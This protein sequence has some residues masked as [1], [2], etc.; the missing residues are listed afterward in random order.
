MHIT[1]FLP[2]GQRRDEE[3]DTEAALL[4]GRATELAVKRALHGCDEVEAVREPESRH[5]QGPN[6]I[7]N[8]LRFVS[9]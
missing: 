6:S 8:I 7:E 2:T 9:A 3:E 1:N 5:L 4:A